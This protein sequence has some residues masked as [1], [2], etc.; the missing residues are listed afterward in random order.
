MSLL[1]YHQL[2]TSY[3]GNGYGLDSDFT[4]TNGRTIICVGDNIFA[5]LLQ[6]HKFHLR[7]K[8]AHHTK[9]WCNEGKTV[10]CSYSPVFLINVKIHE[11]GSKDVYV[12]HSQRPNVYLEN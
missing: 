10:C 12:G 2:A 11:T 7:L 1:Q 4:T 6:K 5:L 8:R 3:G 9:A